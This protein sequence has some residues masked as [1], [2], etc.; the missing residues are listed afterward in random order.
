MT[1]KT[2]K[3]VVVAAAAVVAAYWYWSPFL[4]VR[5]MQAAARSRDAAAFNQH[6]DFPRVR[7]SIKNQFSDKLA[8]K[9]GKTSGSDNDIAKLGAAFGNLLGRAVVN[10]L[11]DA[12]VRPET[13]MQAMEYGR[14][15]VAASDKQ[16]TDAPSKAEG[17]PDGQSSTGR[18]SGDGKVRWS[19]E[20]IGTDKVIAY[21]TDPKKP[22]E[23]NQDK[24]G[25]VMHRNGFATWKLVEVRLPAS[26]K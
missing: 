8:D 18:E 5:Q 12:L 7:E 1:S 4:T 17:N 14:L 2:I 23:G 25:L 11:V 21:A 10:P 22:D 13:I 6:V 16:P 3:A 20:R 9:F 26:N 19:Y 24:F 15:T